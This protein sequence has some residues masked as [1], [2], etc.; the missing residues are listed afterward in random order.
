MLREAVKSGACELDLSPFADVLS[1]IPPELGRLGQ[2]RSLSLRNCAQIRVFGRLAELTALESLDLGCDEPWAKAGARGQIAD[3]SPLALLTALRSLDLSGCKQV[4]DLGPL[5][6]LTALQSLDLSWCHY[7]AG[8]SPLAGLT[9][10]QSLNLEASCHLIAEFSPLAGLTALQSLNLWGCRQ[11]SE[12]SPLA[13]LT[14]LQSLDLDGC[15]QI[16][17]LS[18][19]AGLTALQSLTLEGCRQIS[20]LSPLAGLTALQSL[21]LE[22]CD[23]IAELS[24]LA[25]LSSLGQLDLSWCGRKRALR[26]ADI[27]PL[28]ATL[29]RLWL[30]DSRFLDLPPEVCGNQSND[31]VLPQVRAHLADL[32]AGAD[33]NNEVKVLLLGNGRVG[34]SQL[35]LRL[36]GREFRPDLSSTHGIQVHE[37][38]IPLEGFEKSVQLNYWDFGGQ[39][40]YHG[41]HAL[42]LQ[43]AVV[44]LLLWNP[45]LELAAAQATDSAERQR[46]LSYWLDYLNA[47]A[48]PG[49]RVLL[50]QSQCDRPEQ[51]TDA[52]L[53]DDAYPIRARM[54]ASA[55]TGLGLDLVRAQLKEAVR[56]TLSLRPP[57]PIGANRARVRDRLRKLLAAEQELPAEERRHRLMSRERFEEIC[58]ECGGVS[59]SEALLEFLHNSGVIF[60]RRGL[61]NGSLVLDQNWAL[62]SLYMLF[63]RSRALP[64]LR[65]YGRFSREDLELVGWQ[66]HSREEQRVFLGMMES[67]GICFRYRELGED[68]WEYIAPELLPRASA[69]RR[70]LLLG[71][72]PAGAP[73]AEAR[74]SYGFLHEGLLRNFFSRIGQQAGD[75]PVYWKYGC[76]FYESRTDSRV[77][78]EAKWQEEAAEAGPGALE[79]RAWGP[80][81]AD[82]ITPL[83]EELKRM[84]L[85]RAPEIAWSGARSPAV[86]E[87]R[88]LM[89]DVREAPGIE[90][91]KP[92]LPPGGSSG[93]RQV[94]I[95]YAW[96][97]EET[98]AGRERGKVVEELCAALKADGWKVV[99]DCEQLTYGDSISAFMRELSAADRIVVVLS[100]KYLKSAFCMTELNEIF[101]NTGG[102][103]AGFLRHVVPVSLKDARIG[104]LVARAECSEYWQ[105]EALRLKPHVA[106]LGG[107]SFRKYKQM[108][109]WSYQV[110]DLLDWI[111]DTLHP[112]GIAAIQ[113]NHFAALK[114]MLRTAAGGSEQA[115]GVGRH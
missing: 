11:I 65:G 18:P 82:L 56:D 68:E 35:C 21:N 83:L 19:L 61:L 89:G 85:G 109:V 71:R 30:Y 115:A 59:D 48:T 104:D 90:S 110:G 51:R 10:L 107:D 33:A 24:P 87:P 52:P 45:E 84:P 95:S 57:A 34:K 73:D 8:L 5:A 101:K 112:Q 103:M 108:N 40:I 31:D 22:W 37:H 70:E 2:L 88:G 50:I 77:L 113:R 16:A 86:E 9:A 64:M 43:G 3:L 76:W 39:E 49:G 29:D 78:V 23:Q 44:V 28:V 7:I 14:S 17:D 47:F 36:R 13:G 75:A 32:R 105:Q 100:E 91:L 55:L 53:T 27:E 63:D 102:Q 69:A 62:E 12:L 111:G 1:E 20:D 60:Y 72:V 96:G 80:R 106:H 58:R 74:A 25:A 79:F 41:A 94:Y 114:S 98:D 4:R 46:P 99:R 97:D 66:K 92:A 15:E 81:A 26:F 93:A 38:S 42:F 6:G 54:E 67:C